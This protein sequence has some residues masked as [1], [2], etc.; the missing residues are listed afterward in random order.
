M[1]TDL[2]VETA[3][4][5]LSHL[6]IPSIHALQL[7]SKGL[8][9]LVKT[10]ESTIYRFATVAHEFIPSAN[11]EFDELRSAGVPAAVM[12]GI[13]E[14][15]KTICWRMFQLERNWKGLGP[16][17]LVCLPSA[18]ATPASLQVD[19][20][21]GII[22]NIIAPPNAQPGLYVLDMDDNVLWA[23]HWVRSWLTLGLV[24]MDF[25]QWHGVEY[26]KGHVLFHTADWLEPGAH[27]SPSPALGPPQRKDRYHTHNHSRKRFL[28]TF[29]CSLD[30]GFA[31]IVFP[32]LIIKHTNPEEAELY[33]IPTRKLVQSIS[34]ATQTMKKTS[35]EIITLPPL[36]VTW[37]VLLSDAHVFLSSLETGSV[38]VFERESGACIFSMRSTDYGS[39]TLRFGDYGL[40]S[41]T[42]KAKGVVRRL[43]TVEIERT[44]LVDI[45]PAYHSGMLT[46]KSLCISTCGKH[47]LT[48]NAPWT[49]TNIYSREF[50]VVRNFDEIPPGDTMELQNHAIQIDLDT[51]EMAF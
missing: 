40:S 51:Q 24:F 19:E 25:Q 43:T 30:V 23:R 15:W 5:I 14:S 48:C 3:L 41:D 31:Q 33:D 13:D 4:L 34:L 46:S 38:R 42:A 9:Q 36:R 17:E 35:G 27:A 47:L 12:L 45:V 6:V 44:K 20:S 22:I 2:P 26:N 49:S 16:S 7:V 18:G 39:R 37:T 32:T 50:V 1:L 10:N 11:L 8:N 29:P 28:E 21:E